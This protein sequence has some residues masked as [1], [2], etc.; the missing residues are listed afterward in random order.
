MHIPGVIKI[1]GHLFEVKIKTEEEGFF[2]SGRILLQKGMILLSSNLIE[3]KKVSTL[4]H[5][6]IHEICWQSEIDLSETVTSILA[7]RLYDVLS[8]NKML[9]EK[10]E[11]YGRF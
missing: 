8:T 2:N 1:G 3:S 7:E 9:K 4:F 10:E 6:I 11:E 5:E